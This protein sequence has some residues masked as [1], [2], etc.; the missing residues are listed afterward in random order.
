MWLSMLSM[1][2]VTSLI[3]ITIFN[4]D[5]RFR[6]GEDETFRAMMGT[7]RNISKDYNMTERETMRGP[8]LDN[9]FENHIKKQRE[10]LL[11]R[12]D[13]YG[14]HFQGDGATI[15]ETPLLN[16][17]AGGV[18]LPVSVQNIVDCTCHI[19]CGHKKDSKIVV[20]SFFDPMNDLYP[21]NKTC[22]P[23]YVLWSQ[24]VQKGSICFEGCLSYA[25]M[26]FWGRLYLS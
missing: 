8:L 17:L 4:N 25:V 16:I 19:T 9:C 26:Y 2:S 1:V 24:C 15:K 12:E 11:N 5:L 6:M 7:A 14:L 10:K 3:G 20:D 21:E 13:I 22:G 23:T 18:Y